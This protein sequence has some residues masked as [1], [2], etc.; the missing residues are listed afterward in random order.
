MSEFYY[1]IKGK[2]SEVEDFHNSNWE[3]PPMWSGKITAKDRK[4]AKQLIDEM[5]EHEFKLRILNKDLWRHNFLLFIEK[6]DDDN[7]KAREVFEER[8]CDTCGK[9]FRLIDKYRLGN[10]GGGNNYCSN[11]CKVDN[12]E[13]NRIMD[14]SINGAPVIYKIS[15][16]KTNKCYIGQTTQV[17]TLRWYQHFFQGTSSKFHEEVRNS[18]ITDWSFE[19]LEEIKTKKTKTMD[20]F[21]AVIN[22]R[23]RFYIDK[24]NSVNNGY[25]SI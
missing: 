6:I 17:F 7:W 10:N 18:K 15:N 25:N 23:E 9:D 20:D 4:H 3:W 16:K 11:E 22:E 12:Y 2:R 19:I 13:L 8:I 5:Y 14:E 21:K 24:F 1:V